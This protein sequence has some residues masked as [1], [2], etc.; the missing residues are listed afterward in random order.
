LCNP[1]HHERKCEI[2]TVHAFAGTPDSPKTEDNKK[3]MA[4]H[5]YLQRQY[6][7]EQAMSHLFGEPPISAEKLSE[8][9]KQH[10][11]I[12][13][14]EIDSAE[15]DTAWTQAVRQT[16]DKIARSL[17]Y[18]PVC[19]RK[20]PACSEVM[21]D[22]VW[23]PLEGDQHFVFAMECEWGN[24]RDR[25]GKKY[26]AVAKDVRYDFRK[27]LHVKA[28]LKMLVYTADN[29][30]M[31]T[32]IHR[33]V[34]DAMIHYPYHVEGECYVFVEFVPGNK[35]FRYQF[36]VTKTGRLSQNPEFIPLDEE[37]S[38]ALRPRAAY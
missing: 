24:Q 2:D 11:P 13:A 33:Q 34:K 7:K 19:S 23:F 8:E 18:D 31:R 38:N 27:L 5:P 15:N 21:L 9:L 10:A 16:L 12:L 29:D 3:P 32:A 20:E 37:S 22:Q 30:S 4:T 35:C 26:D 6:G 28:P 1:K 17:D 36:P 25:K 14:R